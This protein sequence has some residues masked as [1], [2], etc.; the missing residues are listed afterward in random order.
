MKDPI[1][2]SYVGSLCFDMALSEEDR[3]TLEEHLAL[4]RLPKG[5]DLWCEG[6]ISDIG[7]AI[8]VSGCVKAVKS[9]E[10]KTS[11]VVLGVLEPCA[12]IGLPFQDT[13]TPRG[14]TIESVKDSELL[15]MDDEMFTH[16]LQDHLDLGLTLLRQIHR[17][18]MRR[19]AFAGE[20]IV[21]SF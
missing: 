11:R 16:L 5:E 12:F 1:V 9:N 6:E 13:A 8:L 18:M 7:M 14:F 15:L 17:D 2:G 19:L 3:A 4:L 20:R 10:F 21:R